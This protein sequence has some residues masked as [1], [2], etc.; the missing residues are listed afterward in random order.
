MPHQ[1]EVLLLILKL[2]VRG[3]FLPVFSYGSGDMLYSISH[4]DFSSQALPLPWILANIFHWSETLFTQLIKLTVHLPCSVSPPVLPSSWL[5]MVILL[6]RIISVIQYNQIGWGSI[7]LSGKWSQP[8]CK[9]LNPSCNRDTIVN[10][11]LVTL[12]IFMKSCS[13]TRWMSY[14]HTVNTFQPFSEVA[15][16]NI[17]GCTD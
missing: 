15:R 17:L 6:G 10:Q 16:A 14:I 3:N 1:T 7:C 5:A 8:G 13:A 9:G 4:F 11:S 12:E 2:P